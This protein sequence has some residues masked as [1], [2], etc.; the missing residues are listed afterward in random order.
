MRSDP[1]GASTPV[2]WPAPRP[3]FMGP[4][5]GDDAGHHQGD[6]EKANQA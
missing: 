3:L 4:E 6:H 5:D 2:V 1:G